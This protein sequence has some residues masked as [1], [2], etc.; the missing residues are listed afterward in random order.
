MSLSEYSLM[1]ILNLVM[2]NNGTAVMDSLKCR[3]TG[4]LSR[5]LDWD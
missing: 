3:D 1:Q 4:L 5:T 2:L